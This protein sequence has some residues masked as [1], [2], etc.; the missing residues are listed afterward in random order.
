MFSKN[1][2]RLNELP[3]FKF[4]LILGVILIHCNIEKYLTT[5]DYTSYGPEI[6]D[7][8]TSLMQVCVP[9]FFIISGYLFF[10]NV[11]D[12]TVEIYK[13]K[14]ISR[15]RTLFI[16]YLIWNL[17]CAA[18]FVIKVLFL[19]F[20]GLGIIENDTINW[21]KF[22]L[23]FIYRE[24][25]DGY[26]Y[27][28]AFWFI[29]NLIAFIILT[30]IVWI[31][32]RKWL[33]VILLFAVKFI[34]DIDFYGIEWFLL[35]ASGSIHNIRMDNIKNVPGLMFL[36]GAI[37]FGLA[38]LRFWFIEN[39]LIGT[40]MLY[41]EVMA[42]FCFVYILSGKLIIFSTTNIGR[43]LCSSTFFLYAFH[44]CFC[45][46]TLKLWL[47]I[48]GYDSILSSLLTYLLTFLSLFIISF[49]TYLLLN[50]YCPKVMRVISGNRI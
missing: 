36:S 47:H 34:F 32:A 49:L 11:E 1:T 48:I 50:K 37:Y 41:V 16:P 27:A 3:I 8:I 45:S 26:P 17:F 2:I 35:G 42:G 10:Y 4:I 43:Q 30:P 23:G 12:F 38:I 13:K 29:R 46:V 31:I 20:P 25:A 44:Q 33:S 39:L 9:S 6:V 24:Q 22:F 19:N 7:F 14:L 40:L 28:F 18:L 21:G 5:S 15:F